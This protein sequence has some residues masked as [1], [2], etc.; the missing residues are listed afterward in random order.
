MPTLARLPIDDV[1]PEL[2]DAL[3]AHPAVVLKAPTGAGKTTRVPPALLDAGVAG[4]GRVVV[5]EPRRLAARAAARRMAAERGERV[6]ETFGYRVRMDRRESA[7]TRV[8][9]MT[10]GLLIRALQDDPFLE[11][12]GAVVLDEFHERSV[13]ADL[14][15]AMVWRVI[16]DVRPDLKLVVMS[17]TLDPAPIARWLGGCPAVIS[18]G[19]TY[20]VERQWLQR[21]PSGRP[22]AVAAMGVRRAVEDEPEGDVLVFLPGVPEIRRTQEELEDWARDRRI[23]VLPL[24]GALPSAEQDR[25]LQA[26][27]RQRVVL[28]TNVAETSV[29]LE[30]I[31]TV[32]DTGLVKQLRYDPNI[33]LDRLERCWISK[34]SA[35]QR[36]GRAGRLGPGRAL[37][38]WTEHAHRALPDR[39]APEIE[40]VDLAGVALELMAWGEPDVAAFGWYHPPPSAALERAL[41]VLRDLDAVDDRGITAVGRQL[42]A[43]PTHPRLA[44]LVYEGHRLGDPNTA[45][46]CAALLSERDPIRRGHG[47]D[48]DRLVGRS[49]SDVR[50][51]LDLL[52]RLSAGQ[53][54]HPRLN[55]GAA[56][57]ILKARDQL[58]RIVRSQWGPAPRPTLSAE[59]ILGKALL[60]AFPDRLARRRAPESARAVMA[61]GRGVRLGPS[62]A[63]LDPELFVCVELDAGTRGVHAEA[64]VRIAHGIDP[65]WLD[66]AKLRD[67]IDVDFDPG[68]GRVQAIARTRYGGLV[69]REQVT[70]A[71]DPARLTE[72]LVEAAST[73]LD[74]VINPDDRDLQSFLT[75]WRCLV[76]WRP[77]LNLPD[78]DDDALRALLPMLCDGRRSLDEV[79]RAPWLD[80]LKGTLDYAHV[81]RL[82]REAPERLTVPSG[83]AIRLTY[84]LDRPPVLAVRIQEMFGLTETPTVAGGRVGVLLH[85]L[86][87][88][89]R[90]QQITDDLASFWANTYPEVRKELRQRYPKHAWPE[91]PLTARPERRPQRRRRR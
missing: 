37:R 18:E 66:D 8:T 59:A 57:F 36:A 20:P 15:L 76:R 30:G 74:Q 78:L 46:L 63:V 89:M 87:P 2:I 58:A 35:E 13:N 21:T 81:Q 88:N 42:V 43:L 12:V 6:G 49:R 39:D 61:S 40:R 7:R 55:R 70:A 1:L 32:V 44:R 54:P 82:E 84:T 19:R 64:L 90:P 86:A 85:L 28:A 77:D 25:A 11:E 72:A 45:A 23:D 4:E 52:E 53:H 51:R 75:R 62:S 91:D 31:R 56:R 79:R 10:E 80:A 14:A 27:P 71:D 68:Q 5:L 34:A 60:A 47:P 33:G 41:G 50:D 69:L 65:D 38:L 29:T 73:R 83:S 48:Q 22:H 67:T 26:G 9:V 3:R 24:Y 16:Q 17:A